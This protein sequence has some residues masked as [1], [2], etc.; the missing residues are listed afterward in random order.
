MFDSFI[1]II[2]DISSYVNVKQL[3]MIAPDNDSPFTQSIRNSII[4]FL[5]L[6]LF[7]FLAFTWDLLFQDPFQRWNMGNFSVPSPA[8]SL[9]YLWINAL[10]YLVVLWYFDHVLP[11]KYKRNQSPI[12]FLLPS[13]W[14]CKKYSTSQIEMNMKA[15]LLVTVCPTSFIYF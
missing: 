8:Q 4:Y 1:K 5:I 10:V 7:F 11:D 9:Q 13:Y 3:D 14:K 15:P 12:F 2:F 6:K